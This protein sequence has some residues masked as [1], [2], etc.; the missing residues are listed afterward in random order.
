[1]ITVEDA[2]HRIL[3][4]I[5]P[6]E[7]EN[8]PLSTALGRYLAEDIKALRSQPPSDVSAMDGYALRYQDLEASTQ[9]RLAGESAAGHG[10]DGVVQQGECI[11]IFTG[12]PVPS[13]AD[14]VIIQ[15]NTIKEDENTIC[16]TDIGS[17]GRNIRL[18]GGD[19]NEGDV[20]CHKGRQMNALD[21]AVIGAGNHSHIN[22]VRK[23]RVAILASGDELV[24]PGSAKHATDIIAV[25]TDMVSHML[26]VEGADVIDLGVTKDNAEAID[27]AVKAC[28]KVDLFI[29]IGGASVGDYDL[30]QPVLKNMGLELDFWKIAMQPGK[31]LIFGDFKGT[32]FLG[33]PGN[34]VSAYVTAFLYALPI[35]RAYQGNKSPTPPTITAKLEHD[36]AENGTRQRYLRAQLCE[37]GDGQITVNSN[38]I[39]DSAALVSM[40][41]S[42][43]LIICPPNMPAQQAG[44]TIQIHRL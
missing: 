3:S 36:L 11:R 16:F 6:L 26:Q 15:E 31:P 22:V 42:N 4:H 32:P 9:L 20:L 27:T 40:A 10:Y 29:T 37:D 1:M 23:P 7:T 8:I 12:A 14:T 24:P 13:G 38:I 44:V 18:M 21:I 39:Q 19:F 34:P 2:T 30:I 28:P 43:A 35:V 25:N 5:T 17:L 33:L 41:R